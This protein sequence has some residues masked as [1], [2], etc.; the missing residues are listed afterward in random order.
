MLR[1]TDKLIRFSHG[2]L[3]SRY[4]YNCAEPELN[5]NP[6]HDPNPVQNVPKNYPDVDL[7][8]VLASIERVQGWKSAFVL[9][10]ESV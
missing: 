2:S 9:T 8:E 5:C 3:S 10:Y 1:N 4:P 7:N 6:V